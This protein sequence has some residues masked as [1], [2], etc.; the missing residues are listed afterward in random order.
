[1]NGIGEENK[2]VKFP[3]SLRKRPLIAECDES[4]FTK[5]STFHFKCISSGRHHSH[6]IEADLR[7]TKHDGF[8]SII[9]TP[10]FV[11]YQ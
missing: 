11:E 5:A 7:L 6:G 10:D 1:M 8:Y 9:N 3:L 2:K 4:G